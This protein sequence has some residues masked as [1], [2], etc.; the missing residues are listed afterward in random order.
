MLR[1]HHGVSLSHL[2]SLFHA[3]LLVR[4]STSFSTSSD[5]MSRPFAINVQ[6]RVK[7]ERRQEFLRVMQS[8]IQQTLGKEP[9]ALQFVLGQDLEQP[10][11]YYL[12]EEYK[13]RH[14]HADLH[15]KTAYYDECM[16]FFATEPFSEPH[17]A[18]EYYLAHD[19][20]SEKVPSRHGTVICLNVELCIQPD[21]RDEFLRVIQNNKRGSDLDEPLC[22]QYS[23]GE[24]IKQP[25]SFYFHEQYQGE[26]GL[27][28]HNAAPHFKVWEDFAVNDPFTKPP[29]VQK[30]KLLELS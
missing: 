28:A 14:D 19:P 24:S 17:Q 9:N 11:I 13:T 21:V 30:Y 1:R 7:P 16:K 6:F 18:D 15:S 10:D 12:H 23:Y 4:Q 8:N 22:L 26:E 2:V 29:V 3:V 27:D 20:P 5:N 25:N